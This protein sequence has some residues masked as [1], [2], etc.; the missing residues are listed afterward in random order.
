MKILFHVDQIE[1]WKTCLANVYNTLK[2]FEDHG[3]SG[4]VE[5]LVNA[6]AVKTLTSAGAEE[7]GVMEELNHY[8][9]KGVKVLACRN[10][11]VGQ[12]IN[13]EDLL[14]GVDITEAGIIEIAEKQAEGWAY[15]RP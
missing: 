10:A 9:N 6:I 3:K 15:V 13:D 4:E 7:E 14:Q 8:M 5:I 11:L 1:R 2:Y 12:N